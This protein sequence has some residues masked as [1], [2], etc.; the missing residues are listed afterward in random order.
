MTEN[1]VSN[2][3]KSNLYVPFNVYKRRTERKR[4]LKKFCF[5]PPGQNKSR[6]FSESVTLCYESMIVLYYEFE[7]V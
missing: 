3:V 5:L 1:L 4:D 7:F 2:S 6:T